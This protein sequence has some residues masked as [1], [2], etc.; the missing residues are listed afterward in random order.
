MCLAAAAITL[1][2]LPNVKRV[3]EDRTQLLAEA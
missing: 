1:L 2:L 3:R